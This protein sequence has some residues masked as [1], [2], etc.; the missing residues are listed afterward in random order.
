M[1]I[2]EYCSSDVFSLE[3][4]KEFFPDYYRRCQEEYAQDKV[5]FVRINT[6]MK[7]KVAHNFA[8][9]LIFF[10][11]LMRTRWIICISCIVGI[12]INVNLMRKEGEKEKTPYLVAIIFFVVVLVGN[13]LFVLVK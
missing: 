10:S 1:S 3:G 2:D 5:M 8:W 11:C 12:T 6:F 7:T 13:V 9:I 4:L